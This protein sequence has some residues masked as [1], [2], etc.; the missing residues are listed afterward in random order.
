METN[1]VQTQKGIQN[2]IITSSDLLKH[3]QGH[4]RL[5]RRVIE[6]FPDDKLFTYSVGGMRPFSE[7]AL[8]MIHMAAPGVRGVLTGKWATFG[9]MEKEKLTPK[10]KEEL[11][12]LWDKTT[13]QIDELWP[14]IPAER[15]REVDVAF[16][17]YEDVNYAT[18]FYFIDN[19]I[20]HR[21]QGYV[22]LRS[23]GIEPPFFWER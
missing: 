14:Q 2:A 23:L 16:G 11:L 5:T 3:W 21:G 6:A 8:E 20:H 10:T 7:L 4:R 22:Y 1:T 12:Q 18:V 17:Q 15:F 19:E 13:E 9:E